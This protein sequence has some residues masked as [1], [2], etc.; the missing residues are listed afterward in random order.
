MR[1]RGVPDVAPFDTERCVRPI[2]V[3]VGWWGNRAFAAGIVVAWNRAS[4]GIRG[5][6][7]RVGN[8]ASA[9]IRE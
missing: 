1:P 2:T 3:A 7:L 9:P 4:G 6:G 8:R 5:Q